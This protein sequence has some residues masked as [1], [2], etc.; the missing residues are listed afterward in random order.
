MRRVG[1]AR[2]MGET[3]GLV[4]LVVDA[5]TDELLGMHVLAHIGADL[6]PQGILLL[7]TPG[8]DGGTSYSLYLHPSDPLRGTESGGDGPETA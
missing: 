7:H 1:R 8:P 6:L 5:D 3:G 2:A 4:K